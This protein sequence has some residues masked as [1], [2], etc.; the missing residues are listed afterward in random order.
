MTEATP[1][2]PTADLHA[3]RTDLASLHAWAER[4]LNN[5]HADRQ[6]IAEH[7][8]ASTAALADGRRLP[9]WRHADIDTD[10]F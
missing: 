9:A 2:D 5:E 7:L 4:V 10:E 3:L 1:T 6:L 8:S